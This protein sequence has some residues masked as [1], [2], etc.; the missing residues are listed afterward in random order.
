MRSRAGGVVLIFIFAVAAYYFLGSGLPLARGKT[1]KATTV[2]GYVN[3]LGAG[4][5]PYRIDQGVDYNGPGDLYA[6]GSGTVVNLYDAGWPGGTYI[7]LLLDG[8]RYKGRYV[9]YAEY[10]KPLT[11]LGHV[12]A[13]QL[14]ARCPAV[15]ACLEIGWADPRSISHNTLAYLLGQSRAG[16]AAGDP[17]FYPT[18]CGVQFSQ[19]IQSLGGTPGLMMS[20]PVQGSSC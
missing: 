14:I 12:N 9:Y 20:S 10:P 3:P 16:L 18:A 7:K 13:G 8:G 6:I 17:G 19:F 15:K 1:A 5:T 2:A 4:L 11:G